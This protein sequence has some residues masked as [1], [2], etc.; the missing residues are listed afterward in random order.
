MPIFQS[1]Y[2]FFLYIKSAFNF[3]EWYPVSTCTSILV[4]VDTTRDWSRKFATGLNMIIWC[5]SKSIWVTRQS[6]CQ[7]DSPMK[8][9]FWPKDSLIT[10]ILFELQPIIIFSPVA[11]FGDQSLILEIISPHYV[12]LRRRRSGAHSFQGDIPWK[13]F[14]C[15]VAT[16]VKG[17]FD[18]VKK[19][20]LI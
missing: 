2:N 11:N 3:F 17:L 19:V 9:T 12:R 5:C 6:F 10:D 14:P 1:I 20:R 18:F 4:Q 15:C 16:L 8:G 7:N 13:N